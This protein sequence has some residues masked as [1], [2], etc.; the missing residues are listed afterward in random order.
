MKIEIFMEDYFRGGIDTFVINLINN[1][2]NPADELILICNHKHSGLAL[3][4]ESITRPFTL[5]KHGMKIFTGL[6]EHPYGKRAINRVTDLML[7]ISSPVVRYIF[8]IYNIFS[9]KRILL[10]HD[11][12]RLLVVNN[13]YPAGDSCRAATIAWGIFSK[14]PYSIHNFHGI[15]LKPGWHIMFQE[16]LVDVFISKFSSVFVSVSAAC[17]NS[18][19]C[20][21]GIYRRHQIKYIYNG[22]DFAQYPKTTN[23]LDLKSELGIPPESRICLMLGAYH[24]NKNFD[25]GHHFLFQSFKKVVE[26]IPS[27][28]LLVC[29]HGSSENI[30]RTRRLALGFNLGNNIHLSGFRNDVPLLLKNTDILLIASQVF[31]SFGLVAIEAMAYAV[32]VV[33]TS[34]G[35]IPEVVINDEGGY[36]VPKDDPDNY[37]NHIIKLLKDNNL[38]IEQGQKGFQRYKRFFT[39]ER[40]AK[41]Y[42]QLIYHD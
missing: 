2:P 15:A 1:W 42:A 7:K 36:C 5:V 3:I 23:R 33:A 19:S 16:R 9:L 21:K 11:P 39:G 18:M 25:K 20:R 38:R 14:K 8:F 37:T 22:I 31:E 12:D 28:H 13:G 4:Q 24:Y 27:A 6:F 10:K 41:E 40:M 34:V 30:E 32:P 35:A 29:G 17:A 26:E